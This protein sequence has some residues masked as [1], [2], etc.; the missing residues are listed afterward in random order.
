MRRKL[1]LAAMLAT[2]LLIPTG[3]SAASTDPVD[4]AY[5][6]G[7]ISNWSACPEASTET[8][9]T[10]FSFDATSGPFGQSPSGTFSF[11]CASSEGQPPESFAGTINCLD[12]FPF[13]TNEGSGSTNVFVNGY[14]AD[15]GGVITS[16]S[17]PFF[18]VGTQISFGAFDGGPTG[19]HDTLSDLFGGP[20]CAGAYVGSHQLVS[21]NLTVDDGDAPASVALTPGTA[22]DVIGT[23][24]TATATVTTAQGAPVAPNTQVVFSVS[25]NTSHT[26]VCSTD[27]NGQCSISYQ[28]AGH[29]GSDVI[30]ACADTFPNGQVDPGEPCGGAGVTWVAPPSVTLAPADAVNT[31]DMSQTLT[32]SVPTPAG[33]VSGGQVLFSIQ[34]A[35]T[36]TGT[37]TTDPSGTCA[38]TYQGPQLPGADVVTACVD[39]NGN[40]SVDAT[41]PCATATVAWLAPTTTPGHVTGGGQIPNATGTDNVA[42][43]FTAQSDSNG[44]KG[45]C[46]LVDPSA[47]VKVKCLDVTTL[48]E[49][50]SQAT[51]FGDATVNGVATTYRID[52]ADLLQTTQSAGQDQFSIQTGNGY[53]AGGTD[54]AQGSGR[55]TSGNIQI[56]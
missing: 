21:G 49:S 50:G 4:H 25:G 27:Q 56:H 2:A 23:Q 9:D 44:V 42:F 36:A 1:A 24:A 5:G 31:V 47:N 30:T 29:T 45:E 13:V 32:A 19:V 55:L 12:V 51:L 6:S 52:V 14:V 17:E 10:S 33:P 34:G 39:A 38:F 41:E 18:P 8:L 26:D 48:T 7:A 35:E 11:N 43:G 20:D 3:A 54:P 22:S 16:S 15:I 40:G 53:R 37:C 28:G 46:T